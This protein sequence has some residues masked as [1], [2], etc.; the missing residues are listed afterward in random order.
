MSRIVHHT[1]S[2]PDWSTRETN[3]IMLHLMWGPCISVSSW[4]PGTKHTNLTI[5][6]TCSNPWRRSPMVLASAMWK[7]G[8]ICFVLWIVLYYSFCSV[9]FQIY[10]INFKFNKYVSQYFL[11]RL[12]SKFVLPF[13]FVFGIPTA[14]FR[15]CCNVWT[16][17][18][19]SCASPVPV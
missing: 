10:S 7:H 2:V 16:E 15:R 14:V 17:L 3:L 19:P 18:K 11:F 4:E 9:W 12:N 1:I 6:N 5:P 13:I 8:G